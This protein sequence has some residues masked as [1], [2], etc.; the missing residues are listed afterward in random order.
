MFCFYL[1]LAI[2]NLRQWQWLYRKTTNFACGSAQESTNF[3]KMSDGVTI[4][5][6]VL[7]VP[8]K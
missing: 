5:D 4:A 3:P 8:Q 6:A 7:F 1:K 2:S